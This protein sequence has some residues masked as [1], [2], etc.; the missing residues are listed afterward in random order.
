[1]FRLITQPPVTSAPTIQSTSGP[2]TRQPTVHIT[3]RPS[4]NPTTIQT[5]PPSPYSSLSPTVIHPTV[6]P[7]TIIPSQ[8]PSTTI[9]PSSNSVNS[10]ATSSVGA[11]QG[12]SLTIVIPIIIV[13]L[14]LIA[15]TLGYVC[16]R[17]NN[18]KSP[19]SRWTEHYSTKNAQPSL[20]SETI[21]D[22]HHFYRKSSTNTPFTP[23]ISHNNTN[24]RYSVQRLSIRQ[25]Y[26]KD[27][28]DR[29]YP[30]DV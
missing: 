25:S 12:Q 15:I 10:L 24:K 17:R 9:P 13:L 1:M 11:S 8:Y 22:M 14:L 16:L 4:I 18:A 27:P 23:H 5:I 7:P 29:R 20:P 2:S 26:N 6:I 19:Y 3:P 28:L 30:Q 21:D